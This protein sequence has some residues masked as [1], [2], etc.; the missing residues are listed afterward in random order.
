[1]LMGAN[2]LSADFLPYGAKSFLLEQ[3]PFEKE[4]GMQRSKQEVAKIITL[5]KFSQSIVFPIL[6]LD[7]P[8]HLKI[9]YDINEDRVG[10]NCTKAIIDK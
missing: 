3:I 4:L 1:M 5:R 6:S 8:C 2:T 9:K 10:L 7:M